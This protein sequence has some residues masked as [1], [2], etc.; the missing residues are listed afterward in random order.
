MVTSHNG[1]KTLVWSLTI[2]WI[3]NLKSLYVLLNTKTC[4]ILIRT[5]TRAE[6]ILSR[7][8]S[9]LYFSAVLEYKCTS[10]L[11]MTTEC[12]ANQWL[13]FEHQSDEMFI[14]MRIPQVIICWIWFS[15]VSR[16][17]PDI[18]VI[19]V[20]LTKKSYE[21][22]GLRLAKWILSTEH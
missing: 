19:S 22:W 2:C 17:Q 1:W 10:F 5:V 9:K 15:W 12:K 11:T 14:S 6:L 4:Q 13:L 8:T 20:F 3:Q 7:A 21:E 18:Y 16:L